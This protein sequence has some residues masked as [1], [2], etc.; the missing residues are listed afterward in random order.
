MMGLDVIMEQIPAGAIVLTVRT[1]E[2]YAPVPLGLVP[3]QT[4]LILVLSRTL[5]ASEESFLLLDQV[6]NQRELR[7]FDVDE[8]LLDKDS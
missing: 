4:R 7:L 6:L 8:L 2:L 5:V 3:C 1:T